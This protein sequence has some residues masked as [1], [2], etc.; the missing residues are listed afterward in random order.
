MVEKDSYDQWLKKIKTSTPEDRFL[1]LDLKDEWET[2]CS[3]LEVP[4]PD[5]PFPRNDKLDIIKVGELYPIEKELNNNKSDIVPKQNKPSR[6]RNL[7][8]PVIL[9]ICFAYGINRKQRNWYCF[10]GMLPCKKCILFNLRNMLTTFTN[11]ALHYILK[12]NYF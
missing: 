7:T 5:L 10:G 3:F 6:L 4:V 8:V 11:N 1:I 9:L 12:L 2:I